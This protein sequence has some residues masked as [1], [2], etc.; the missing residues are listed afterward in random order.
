MRRFNLTFPRLSTCRLNHPNK[1]LT[2]S[3]HGASHPLNLSF[4]RH[5]RVSLRGRGYR[6][7]FRYLRL[8][9]RYVFWLFQVPFVYTFFA[10]ARESY[11]KHTYLNIFPRVFLN[12]LLTCSLLQPFYHSPTK[13]HTPRRCLA[14]PIRLSGSRKLWAVLWQR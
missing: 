5:V 13:P 10:T 14:I 9:A 2:V 7:P 3:H 8:L 4:D 1:P 12:V 6:P 11:N